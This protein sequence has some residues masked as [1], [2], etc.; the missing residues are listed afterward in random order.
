MK[1]IIL[2]TPFLDPEMMA[3]HTSR[4]LI[5]ESPWRTRNQA[6]INIYRY[7]LDLPT[8][9][10]HVPEI[11][12]DYTVHTLLENIYPRLGQ[13]IIK[14][15][16]LDLY[17]NRVD[18]FFS[19]FLTAVSPNRPYNP[20]AGLKILEKGHFHTDLVK[21]KITKTITVDGPMDRS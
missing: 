21:P 9:G 17:R 3:N 6:E 1:S 15:K 16:R 20:Q 2:K 10:E 4:R 14:I 5:Y 7:Q 8:V 12:K 11:E 13:L 19:Q 18:G